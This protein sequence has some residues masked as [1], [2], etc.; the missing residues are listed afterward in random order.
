[1]SAESA[2]IRASLMIA[3]TPALRPALRRPPGSQSDQLLS[4]ISDGGASIYPARCLFLSAV[5]RTRLRSR[6]DFG[7]TSSSSS[8]SI[9][10]SAASSVGMR[11][12]DSRIASSW[13][14]A[15]MLLSFFSRHTLTGKFADDHPLVNRLAG[16]DEEYPALLQMEDRVRRGDALA[17]G[18]HRAV[19]ARANRARPR[20][21]AVEQR[22]H[23]AVAAGAFEKA[24]AKADQAARGN[25]VLQAHAIAR[26]RDHR[27][28]LGLARRE[29]LRD[30]ADAL[31]RDVDDE[32]LHRF[33]YL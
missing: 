7:V 5:L 31:G 32:H 23:Q 25:V 13:P 14:D 15:R 9:H 12:G 20:R 2:A 3:V 26:V 19:G 27:A 29:H 33:E 11:A 4:D 10:S 1:M 24:A 28:H 18:N 21:V 16:S 30:D 6:T 22:I 8:S 17:I